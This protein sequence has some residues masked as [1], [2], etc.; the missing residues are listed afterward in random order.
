MLYIKDNKGITLPI[1]LLVLAVLSIFGMT[2]LFITSSQAKLNYK[3]DTSKQALDYAEAGYNAYLWH[4]NDDVNFYS[5]EK[6]ND[7]MNKPIEFKDDYYM[8]EVTK[9]SDIDRFVT[10]LQ[11]D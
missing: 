1:V 4:L 5:T 11:V 9:P 6:H 2:T 7:M 10:I 3:D 8:L